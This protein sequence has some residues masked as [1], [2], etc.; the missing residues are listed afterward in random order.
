M[1]NY[2]YLEQ[3]SQDVRVPIKSYLEKELTQE[4]FLDVKSDQAERFLHSLVRSFKN[5]HQVDTESPEHINKSSNSSKQKKKKN[6]KRRVKKFR[7]RAKIADLYNL[8]LNLQLLEQELQIKEKV[9]SQIPIIMKRKAKSSSKKSN[10]DPLLNQIRENENN[11]VDGDFFEGNNTKTKKEWVNQK[12]YLHQFQN[13]KIEVD[14]NKDGSMHL[15]Q[16]RKGEG[17]KINM[18][19]LSPSQHLNNQHAFTWDNR[20]SKDNRKESNIS[21]AST[22]TRQSLSEFPENSDHFSFAKMKVVK[23]PWERKLT[24]NS[25]LNYKPNVVTK[26]KKK[27]KV[28]RTNSILDEEFQQFYSAFE[29]HCQL[30]SNY[31]SPVQKSDASIRLCSNSS[32]SSP[33]HSLFPSSGPLRANKYGRRITTMGGM[34][35]E[36]EN[37]NEFKLYPL[38]TS[39]V[40]SVMNWLKQIEDE[41]EDEDN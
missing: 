25:V 11:E 39:K 2:W 32:T 4:Q 21:N 18:N 26:T 23:K 8:T 41:I 24:T 35:T 15:K 5:N 10:K 19:K 7:K 38:P 13:Y 12:E 1:L 37:R 29:D 27:R 14:K 40:I 30:K 22:K 9:Q 33:E 34:T 6:G 17:L 20:L 3:K 31:L 28:R 16:A 36:S